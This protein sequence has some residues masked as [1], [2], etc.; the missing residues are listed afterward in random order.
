[1]ALSSSPSS[2]TSASSSSSLPESPASRSAESPSSPSPS[3]KEQSEKEESEEASEEE[4]EEAEKDRDEGQ[5]SWNPY[6]SSKTNVYTASSSRV[7]ISS[8]PL[9]QGH[10]KPASADE[11][12]FHNPLNPHF[13]L[14]DSVRDIL[15]DETVTRDLPDSDLLKSVHRY[16]AEY[17]EAKGWDKVMGRSMDESALLAIGLILEEYCREMVGENGGMVFA[18]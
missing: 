2:S 1:M 3:E 13:K 17:F 14:P 18:E 7:T 4:E 16:A 15:E 9:S 11:I 6:S 10:S 12:I 5:S 8:R